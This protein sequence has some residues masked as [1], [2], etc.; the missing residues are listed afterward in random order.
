MAR[1]NGVRLQPAIR[2]E[3]R[4]S[5]RE[6][7]AT[8][9]GVGFLSEA[10]LGNDARLCKYALDGVS[11]YMSETLVTLSARRDVSVIRAFLKHVS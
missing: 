6:V 3:G 2:V 11:L 1:D 10:E 5:L 8:G 7:V 9:A 4:E